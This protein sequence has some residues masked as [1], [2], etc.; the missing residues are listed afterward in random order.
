MVFTY[1]TIQNLKKITL[2]RT[3]LS[4][5]SLS[6]TTTPLKPLRFSKQMST[7]KLIFEFSHL[8]YK[9][10]GCLSDR[11]FPSGKIIRFEEIRNR[12]LA[13]SKLRMPGK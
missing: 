3:I 1:E 13:A 7:N 4:D 9:K 2:F 10:L 6:L 12:K 11:T 8:T 5:I